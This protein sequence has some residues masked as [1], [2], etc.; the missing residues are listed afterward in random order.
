MYENLEQTLHGFLIFDYEV[1]FD[2]VRQHDSETLPAEERSVPE[3]FEIHET[4]VLPIHPEPGRGPSERNVLYVVN[5]YG[6]RG[7]LDLDVLIL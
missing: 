6:M 1:N 7:L 2:F 4:E 3:I 5:D